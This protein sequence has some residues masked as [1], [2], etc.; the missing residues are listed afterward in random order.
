MACGDSRSTVFGGRLWSARA[1]AGEGRCSVRSYRVHD[2]DSGDSYEAVPCG[3]D[4]VVPAPAGRRRDFELTRVACWSSGLEKL[5]LRAGDSVHIWHAEAGTFQCCAAEEVTTD[6]SQCTVLDGP[7]LALLSPGRLLLEPLQQSGSRPVV[8]TLEEQEPAQGILSGTSCQVTICE[9]SSWI[10]LCVLALREGAY[11]VAASATQT[12]RLAASSFLG[13]LY[14]SCGL[15]ACLVTLPSGHSNA[16]VTSWAQV[17]TVFHANV[18]VACTASGSLLVIES[19]CPRYRCQLPSSDVA[20]LQGSF[21]CGSLDYVLVSFGSGG[22]A[23]I[24][25]DANG[26]FQLGE[27]IEPGPEVCCGD[28]LGLGSEQVVAWEPASGHIRCIQPSQFA[29]QHEEDEAATAGSQASQAL[30]TLLQH[31]SGASQAALEKLRRAREQAEALLHETT[32]PLLAA[33]SN[34]VRKMALLPVL[35]L[36]QQ[37]VEEVEQEVQVLEEARL[38]D[39]WAHVWGRRL[40]LGFR[41]TQPPGME[42]QPS[43][44]LVVSPGV[45]FG[46]KTLLEEGTLVVGASCRFPSGTA[47]P[48]TV[49]VL[50]GTVLRH[51]CEIDVHRLPWSKQGRVLPRL[52]LW[53]LTAAQ[54]SRHFTTSTSVAWRLSSVDGLTR[55]Y[56]TFYVC[57]DGASPL[58]QASVE[59]L[60]EGRLCLRA[61]YVPALLYSFF[62]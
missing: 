38:L 2:D 60:P 52:A 49:C 31:Y 14:E 12:I 55:L 33:D 56:N 51:Q 7:T 32:Q 20:R 22:G 58:F 39:S 42:Q 57:C 54:P 44:V 16:P 37:P 4:L 47:G 13:S 5:V 29:V 34:P 18:T 30:V 36:E 53:S 23:V 10:L 40:L 48:M 8:V 41:F 43:S 24:S 45:T 26:R 15:T 27:C 1:P 9:E 35:P 61:Q 6:V 21:F 3:G 25:Q 19:G 46:V 17:K 59:L 11:F 50:G 28:L 62:A